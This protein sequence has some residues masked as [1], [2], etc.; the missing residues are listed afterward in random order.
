MLAFN[1]TYI[2]IPEGRVALIG[3]NEQSYQYDMSK[4]A[5]TVLQ[6]SWLGLIVFWHP[7]TMASSDGIWACG[8]GAT[9]NCWKQYFGT[10]TFTD[11]NKNMKQNS[12][13]FASS[14]IMG[15]IFVTPGK[16][17]SKIHIS[18]M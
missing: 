1:T 15:G 5:A 11:Q 17:G 4:G 16:A 6:D 3:H 13:G 2:R 9:V 10:N 14:L 7:N 12:D 18:L 8:G